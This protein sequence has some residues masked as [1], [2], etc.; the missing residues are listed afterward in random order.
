MACRFLKV[1]GAKRNVF[2][3]SRCPPC[4]RRRVTWNYSCSVMGRLLLAGTTPKFG[5]VDQ[6]RTTLSST[7]PPR[8]NSRLCFRVYWGTESCNTVSSLQEISLSLSVYLSHTHCRFSHLLPCS[9]WA[10]KRSG[11]GR[12]AHTKCLHPPPSYHGCQ[13]Q[14]SRSWSLLAFSKQIRIFRCSDWRGKSSQS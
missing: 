9:R 6:P 2:L 10:N 5:S 7:I 13:Q 14:H 11:A 4:P 1:W 8:H 12:S 3:S